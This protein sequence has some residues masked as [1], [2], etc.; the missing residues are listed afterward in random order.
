MQATKSIDDNDSNQSEVIRPG[1]W[2][3]ASVFAILLIAFVYFKIVQCSY[4]TMAT[5]GQFGDLFGGLNAIFSGLAFAGL[6]LALY[7]Q[8]KE[9]SLQRQ[10]LALTREELE[11]STKAQEESSKQL[12]KQAELARRQLEEDNRPFINPYFDIGKRSVYLVIENTG[13]SPAYELEILVVEKFQIAEL[14]TSERIK[15]AI[16]KFKLLVVPRGGVYRLPI[17]ENHEFSRFFTLP[18]HESIRLKFKFIHKSKLQEFTINAG[19]GH[20]KYIQIAER[21][22]DVA[23]LEKINTALGRIDAQISRVCNKL[24]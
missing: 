5:R 8:R 21:Q 17:L 23:A 1:I 20:L 10:E 4:E 6:L 18:E 3:L 7:M 19:I 14:A 11:K 9:L 16:E 22:D 12:F 2:I 15:G 24:K 13:N